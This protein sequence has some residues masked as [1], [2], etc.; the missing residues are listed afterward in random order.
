MR[1]FRT[2]CC[3]IATLSMCC[4]P[5][6]HAQDVAAQSTPSVVAAGQEG[7]E[8]YFTLQPIEPAA[9]KLLATPL[10]PANR[11]LFTDNSIRQLQDWDLPSK[12]TAW[13]DRP[14]PEDLARKWDELNKQWSAGAQN[15]DKSKP[16]VPQGHAAPYNAS[17]LPAKEWRDLEKWLGKNAPKKVSGLCVDSAKATYVLAVGIVS[18]GAG[19][20]PNDSNRVGEY[21][22][23]ASKPRLTDLGPNAGT[24]GP[25]KTPTD[26]FTGSGTS[27]GLP[28]NTCVYLYRTNGKTMGA[29]GARQEAPE[30]YY[31]H[32]GGGISQSTV[33]TMLKYLSKIGLR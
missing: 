26:E 29:G 30:F 5:A 12:V 6:G 13:R 14:S 2:F 8:F 18:G 4:A 22:D 28:G 11:T 3:A 25:Y 7:C 27:N 10:V 32:G 16:N 33:T 31:C 20:A 1:G 21:A 19:L 17:A 9:L 24:V 23:Y 15:K